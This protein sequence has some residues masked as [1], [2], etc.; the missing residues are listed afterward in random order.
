[1][2]ARERSVRPAEEVAIR[3]AEA[4]IGHV[5]ADPALLATA[6]THPSHVS[7][8]VEAMAFQRLEFLGDS[9]L[10]LVVVEELFRRFPDAPE[11]DLTKLK[12]T[13]VSGPTLSQVMRETDLGELVVLGVSEMRTEGR[14]MT[15]ALA[16]CFEAVIAAL[17]LDAGL[18]AVKAFVLPALSSRVEAGPEGAGVEHPKSALQELAQA[19]RR[20]PVYETLAEEGPPHERW[21]T[22][23]VLLDGEALG[24]GGGRSKKEA[25]MNAAAAAL[26]RLRERG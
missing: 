24:E 12:V 6:L 9:V 25:E 3:Q 5:F 13:L 15:S 22:V 8:P 16:D 14:G 21:F 18:A 19:T 11:G 20:A 4:V 23:R 1:M 17:Y 2:P 7:D 10:D 26:E